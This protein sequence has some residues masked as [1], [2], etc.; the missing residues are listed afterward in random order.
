MGALK[1]PVPANPYGEPE[2]RLV[3]DC[4][5]TFT[6]DCLDIRRRAEISEWEGDPD[7]FDIADFTTQRSECPTC[8]CCSEENDE[9][10]RDETDEDGDEYLCTGCGKKYY[11][12][13][14]AVDCHPDD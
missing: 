13:D 1:I 4:G 3:C 2:E 8:S 6:R 14:E 11:D 5:H 12:E 7:D 9:I 10:S